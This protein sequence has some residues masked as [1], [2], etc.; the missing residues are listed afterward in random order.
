MNVVQELCLPAGSCFS[1]RMMARVRALTRTVLAMGLAFGVAGCG[2]SLTPLP[3]GSIAGR[4]GIYDYSPSVIQSGGLQQSWWCGG[5]YNP[6]GTTYFSDTIQ[7]QS[8]NMSTGVHDGPMTVLGETP[9]AWD[10][11]FTCNP[12]VVGGFFADPLNTG[13]SFTYAMYY[14]GLGS[15]P[16]SNNYIGVAFSNDGMSWKKFPY[17]VISPET[18][19]GYGVG[20]PAAYNSNRQGAILLFYEDDSLYPRH[21]EAKSSDGVHFVTVGTL[22]TNGLD[23]S[24][25]TWGDI[26]YDAANGYWYAGFN[27]PTRD[28]STTGGVMER[29]SW[30]VELFRI[31][32]ASLLTGAT[33][34]ELLAI[35]DTNL[36]GYEANFLP[37]LVR[38]MYGN[39]ISDPA[40]QMYTSISNPPPSWNASPEA[41]GTSGDIS[42]WNIAS[43]TWTPGNPLTAFNRYFNQTV[44]E[45]TTGWVDP[46]GNFSLQS[47]LGHLYQS[48]QQGATVPFYGCKNGSTDY[49]VSLDGLCEGAR[50]LGTNGFAYSRPVAGLNLVA[51]YRCSTGHDH[52]VSKDPECEGQSTQELLGYVLP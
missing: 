30:G 35:V 24:N 17:P 16:G 43:A 6:P 42:N 26:A 46:K 34:W 21:V 15:D 33:P 11:V 39:L 5:A 20:Q 10:S 28:P 37:G 18:S 48:P 12:K 40:I 13:E 7:Y 45:V 49:F 38:D 51:L 1:D 2:F 8:I 25:Q 52:F 44:H 32:D 31:C 41:A 36:N 9:G 27:T 4:A 19:K 3:P 23:A 22:T 50:I 47:T 29:G 14:V